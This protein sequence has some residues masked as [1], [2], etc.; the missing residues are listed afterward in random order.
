MLRR[1]V[2]GDHTVHRRGALKAGA[3]RTVRPHARITT[4]PLQ[5]AAEGT[6]GVMQLRVHPRGHTATAAGSGGVIQLRARPRGRL[7]AQ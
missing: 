3:D 5:E 6:E 1:V 7:A 2:P 4:V